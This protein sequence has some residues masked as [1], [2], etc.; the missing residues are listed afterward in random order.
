MAWILFATISYFFN[1]VT[2]V[3]DKFLLKKSIPSPAA[4]TFFVGILSIFAV[5]LIPF[6][7]AW[8]GLILTI[9]NL[10]PGIIF[11]WAVFF[12]VTAV[13][14]YEVSRVV[15]MIGGF[16]PI[17]TLVLSFFIFGEKLS[18]LH[19]LAFIILV[20]GGVL[21]S[22]KRSGDESVKHKPVLLGIGI[23]I[24]AAFAFALYYVSA[25]F[26]FSTDQPFLSA[27]FWSRMG[28]FITAIFILIIPFWRHLIFETRQT[29]S[30]KGGALFAGNKVLAAVAFILLNYSIKL[31]DVALINAIQGVQYVF[32]LGLVAILAK[33]YPT[34]LEEKFTRPIIAQKIFAIIF[35]SFGLAL[36]YF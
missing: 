19:F 4:Y 8:P 28:S 22:F 10:V 24:L 36:L 6:G 13:K 11:F 15:T 29:V 7:V 30:V 33:K 16:A 26:I 31:G 2:A 18:R 23:S 14:K 1:A 25:K 32:L 5:I 12:F 21:I 20:A 27:F 35:I 3:I 17:F 34:V 9:Q